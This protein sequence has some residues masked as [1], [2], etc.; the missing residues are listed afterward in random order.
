MP[1]LAAQSLPVVPRT[2]KPL[3]AAESQI[4]ATVSRLGST[5]AEIAADAH[6]KPI[7]KVFT[8]RKALLIVGDMRILVCWFRF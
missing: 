7:S 6:V 8:C 4:A 3:P 2:P 5:R 1:H